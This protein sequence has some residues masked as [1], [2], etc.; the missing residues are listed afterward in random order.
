MYLARRRGAAGF[1]RAVAIKVV[2]PHLARDKKFVQ[3]FLDEARLAVRI[4]HPNVVR[5]FDAG[6]TSA[7]NL[8]MA[9]EF[10]EGINLAQ[11]MAREQRLALD[12]YRSGLDDYITVLQAQASALTAESQWLVVR[13]TRLDNRVDLHAALGGGFEYDP[14]EF[15]LQD[16]RGDGTYHTATA[17]TGE[18]SR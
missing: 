12:R 7:G 1:Q 18:E 5:L 15:E 2:H 13:R 11:V 8:Y 14:D 17:D 3:M 10:V 4:Q 9:M 16:F 6:T